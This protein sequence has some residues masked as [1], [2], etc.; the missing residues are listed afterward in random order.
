MTYQSFYDRLNNEMSFEEIRDLSVASYKDRKYGDTMKIARQ[1]M[2][3]EDAHEVGP[4]V[5]FTI[6]K[7]QRVES[8]GVP[9]QRA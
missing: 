2:R 8:R 7:A 1:S 3:V 9:R 6:Q 5:A 4:F